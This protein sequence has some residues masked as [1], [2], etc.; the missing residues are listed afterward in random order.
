MNYLFEITIFFI[1]AFIYLHV[2]YHFKTSNDYEIYE[3]DEL[4][5]DKLNEVC[6]LRQPVVFYYDNPISETCRFSKLSS[7]TGGLDVKIRDISEINDSDELYIP[8]TL[9]NSVK[10]L[11]G[12]NETK[13]ITEKNGEFIKEVGLDKHFKMNE[14]FIK[15]YLANVSE[16]DML[17]GSNGSYTPLRYDLNYRNYYYVTEGSVSVKLTP[18]NSGKYLTK[19]KDFENFE[20][21]SPM[22]PWNVQKQYETEFSKLRFVE[23]TL[24]PGMMFQIPPYWWYSMRFT[25]NT[26]L[27]SFKYKTIMNTVSI[28]PLL[29]VHLLQSFNIKRKFMKTFF[30]K[31]V[32][33]TVTNSDSKL[34]KDKPISDNLKKEKDIESKKDDKKTRETNKKLDNEILQNNIIKPA[35]NSDTLSP[36]LIKHTEIK[37]RTLRTN[38]K[39]PSPVNETVQVL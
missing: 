27:V 9:H 19:E 16:Y 15:P 7:E 18:P 33:N 13:Y 30:P 25:P 22:N 34:L 38:E 39:Q 1:I 3:L 14:E 6:D 4:T 37:K 5:K 36:Q 35:L 20:F 12:D 32:T 28:A 29:F 31:K 10:L 26:T 17:S 21:R 8:L 23:I 11:K 24:T 2:N